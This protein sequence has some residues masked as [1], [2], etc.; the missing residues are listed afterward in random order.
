MNRAII[1]IVL[2]VALV[3][4]TQ[5]P[6]TEGA[7]AAPA[8]SSTV[9]VPEDPTTPLSSM[10]PPTNSVRRVLIIGDSLTVG[11]SPHWPSN[12]ESLRVDINAKEGRPLQQVNRIVAD[13]VEHTD[14]YV[15][16]LG[17]NDCMGNP[18]EDQIRDL[19]ISALNT[20]QAKPVLLLTLG[21]RGEIQDCAA[22]FNSVAKRLAASIP[23]LELGDWQAL[24]GDH[25]E[26]YGANGDGIHLTPS[27][28]K[29]RAE[30]LNSLISA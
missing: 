27:G 2:I 16:A 26:W 13:T 25:T 10:L 22:R 18:D 11:T 4:F 30:W 5:Q 21:E 9:A 3:Y 19:I 6:E 28:Y 17:T 20:S 23:S 7:Q 24:A 15:L 1:W 8:P 12:G 29:A 14:A